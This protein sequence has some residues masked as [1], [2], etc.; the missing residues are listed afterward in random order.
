MQL[1]E[2]GN[3]SVKQGEMKLGNIDCGYLPDSSVVSIPLLV[4]NGTEPGPTLLLTAAMH[5]AELTG[6]EVIRRLLREIIDPQKLRGMVIAAPILNPFAFRSASMITPQDGHNLNRVFPGDPKTLLSHRLAHL[7]F[8]QLVARADY[9][10]DFH[11]N[12]FPALQF[13]FIKEGDD[14][15]VWRKSR[16]MAAAFGITTVEM[17]S[18]YERHRQGT[19]GECAANEGK[20]NLT[21]ELIYWRRI[22]ETSVQTG[23]CGTCNVMKHLKMIDGEIE[24]QQGI[25]VFGGR[26]TRMEL[27]AQKGG[28]IHYFKDAGDPIAKGQVIAVMRDPWGDIVEE[29]K[30]PCDGWVLAWPLLENQALATGDLM[31]MVLCPKA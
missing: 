16:E 18:N 13:S 3:I 5:G 17:I 10:I 26:M 4:A 24:K 9:L 6:I 15:D 8:T 1:I 20:P 28:L 31:L 14:K 25:E 7:I 27:T 22:N 21:I 29:I 23:I 11:A 19:I 2:I 30:S 12:P